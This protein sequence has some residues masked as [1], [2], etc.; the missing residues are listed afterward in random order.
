MLVF[1]SVILSDWILACETLS[2]ENPTESLVDFVYLKD[3]YHCVLNW[4]K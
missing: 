2:Q 1:I 4:N 3:L